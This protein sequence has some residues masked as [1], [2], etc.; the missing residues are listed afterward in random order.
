M[1]S[2]NTEEIQEFLDESIKGIPIIRKYVAIY[3]A[4]LMSWSEWKEKRM[5]MFFFFLQ[6][7]DT[8]KFVISYE[9]TVPVMFDLSYWQKPS[10]K[11]N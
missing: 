4:K 6:H 3:L 10:D 2:S 7:L 8:F 1:T 5:C 11:I 9:V